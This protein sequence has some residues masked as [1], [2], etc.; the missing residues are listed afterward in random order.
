VLAVAALGWQRLSR[1]DIDL[2]E[3]LVPLY[4]REPAIGPQPAVT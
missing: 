1:G 2:A 4:L 3:S